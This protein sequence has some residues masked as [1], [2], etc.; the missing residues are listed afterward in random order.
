MS[1]KLLLQL[2]SQTLKITLFFTF[3]LF[4]NLLFLVIFSSLDI[5]VYI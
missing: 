1:I 2:F 3:I 5:F 4:M